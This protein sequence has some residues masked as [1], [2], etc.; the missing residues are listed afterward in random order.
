MSSMSVWYLFIFVLIR[1]CSYYYYY[2]YL[3]AV[4]VVLVSIAFTT[5][6]CNQIF[7]I[8]SVSEITIWP[9]QICKRCCPPKYWDN[10]SEFSIRLTVISGAMSLNCF[11]FAYVTYGRF[12]R[13]YI[14]NQLWIGI[15]FV[16]MSKVWFSLKC[17]S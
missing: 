9:I 10:K 17:L 16:E 15:L 5:L 12:K 4:I 2:Y 3:V 7:E 8:Y 11:V 14:T 13:K 6:R 1:S